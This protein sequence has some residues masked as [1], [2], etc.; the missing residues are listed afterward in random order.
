MT[1]SSMNIEYVK[2]L[3]GL[4]HDVE[5][6]IRVFGLIESIGYDKTSYFI[7][8]TK[9]HIGQPSF[10][11]ELNAKDNKAGYMMSL[12]RWMLFSIEANNVN[13]NEM[14]CVDDISLQNEIFVD[15][16]CRYKSLS[17][18]NFAIFLTEMTPLE[19]DPNDSVMRGIKMASVNVGSSAP[20]MK[21]NMKSEFTDTAMRRDKTTTPVKEDPMYRDFFTQPQETQFADILSHLEKRPSEDPQ[22]E[23]M[24]QIAPPSKRVKVKHEHVDN[25]QE[26]SDDDDDSGKEQWEEV[27]D[28]LPLPQLYR[29][30]IEPSTKMTNVPQ[31]HKHDEEDSDETEFLEAPEQIQL[32][33]LSRGKSEP[34]TKMTNAPRL[35]GY[36]ELEE[37]EEE[38]DSD[39]TEFLEAAGQVHLARSS[40][41]KTMLLTKMADISQLNNSDQEFEYVG[42]VTGYTQIT[43]E[44]YRYD[45]VLMSDS[46]DI[47]SVQGS[48]EV[49]GPPGLMVGLYT[50]KCKTWLREYHI[51]IIEYLLVDY[52]LIDSNLYKDDED[53]DELVPFDEIDTRQGGE[54]F[55][56]FV[57]LCVAIS[58]EHETGTNGYKEMMITDFGVN[59]N[60]QCKYFFDRYI[61]SWEALQLRH[62]QGIRIKIFNNYFAKFDEDIKRRYNGM[63]IFDQVKDDQ[64]NKFGNISNRR[65][66]I[67]FTLRVKRFGGR[68]DAIMKGHKILTRLPG[69]AGAPPTTS[70]SVFSDR[71]GARAAMIMATCQEI[72]H[73]YRQLLTVNKQLS[74]RRHGPDKTLDNLNGTE[75]FQIVKVV[76]ML[77]TYGGKTF[78]GKRT[79]PQVELLCQ[80]A[81]GDPEEEQTEEVADADDEWVPDPTRRTEL[82]RL[83]V[84]DPSL[85][86]LGDNDDV[87]GR[88]LK[89]ADSLAKVRAR[90]RAARMWTEVRRELLPQKL[91]APVARLIADELALQ[92]L[93]G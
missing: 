93:L 8:V 5:H 17:N 3:K 26:E 23:Y 65:I 10:K 34:S 53:E 22:S 91:R 44:L 74:A 67:E 66:I 90:T 36:D 49:Y 42:Y 31:L 7:T 70:S 29:G 75:Q 63:S 43:R 79:P 35:N 1:L 15:C 89:L 28:K 69:T 6:K 48:I 12:M 18:G 38:E 78:V 24:S 37:E 9:R 32:P 58:R 62:D 54:K 64:Y 56:R 77:L 27:A 14:F 13:I 46:E 59:P 61:D 84:H 72:K 21:R 81:F 68:I 55:I 16:L 86:F 80:G 47:N 82:I 20:M 45:T 83:V 85:F 11:I 4:K 52:D 50:F 71:V 92:Q 40:R 60:E 87:A 41:G 51:N 25:L 39:E 19:Y 76:D 57:G 73:K 2:D 30:T 33:Q 88:R